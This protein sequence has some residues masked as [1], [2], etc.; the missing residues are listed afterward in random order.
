[1]YPPIQIKNSLSVCSISF[2]LK[3][4]GARSDI[5]FSNNLMLMVSFPQKG[6][7]GR[8]SAP[9]LLVLSL[10]SLSR[11]K[12][13]SRKKSTAESSETIRLIAIVINHVST[14]LRTVL[15]SFYSPKKDPAPLARLKVVI[16]IK[17]Y[18]L[19]FLLFF[20]SFFFEETLLIIVHS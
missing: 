16:S 5:V 7:Q 3:E 11:T 6:S 2:E 10:N 13:L 1:M 4:G 19:R 12:H 17:F 8:T 14:R 9:E 18:A 15:G 20:L